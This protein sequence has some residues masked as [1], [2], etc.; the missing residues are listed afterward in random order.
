MI[1][2]QW[3][4]VS[5]KRPLSI[6]GVK[7][8]LLGNRCAE[9]SMFDQTLRDLEAHLG[10]A[11][12]D[13][14]AD[15]MA[16]RISEGR[17]I[18]LA[19]D[20]DCDGITSAAQ[21]A[22]FLTDIGYRN[23][24]VA[25]PRREEG[26]G[27]PERAVHEHPDAGLFVAMDCGTLDVKAVTTARATGAACI[28]IDHHEV[29][30]KGLAP[31]SVLINPKQRSCPSEFKEFC[32]AGLT[33]L[34]LA[35][36]RRAL[37]GDF[38]DLK[39]GGKYLALAAIGTVADMAP[40]VK[41]NRIIV[42][43]GLRSIND[44][45]SPAVMEIAAVAGLSGKQ[46]TSGH[47]GYYIGPRV[48]AAGRMGDPAV[49]FRLLTSEN[50]EEITNLARDLNL[51]NAGRQRQEEIILQEIKER[52]TDDHARRRTFVMGDAGW[53]P[54]VIGIV[55]SRV[56]QEIH[57]GPAIVF[58][59]DPS[60]GVARGSARSVPGFDIHLALTRCEDLLTRWGGHKMAAGM[61]VEL[62]RL[63]AFAARFE[64]VAQ[65]FSPDAFVPKGRVDMELELGLIGPQLLDLLTLLEPYGLGNP[66]PVFAARGARVVVEKTFGKERNHLRLRFGNGLEGIYW[67]GA[68]RFPSGHSGDGGGLDVVFNVEWDS[69]C[70]KTILNVRDV[71]RFF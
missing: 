4:I 39:L 3:Q 58:T 17:K 18:V 50:L 25:I 57:Y 15:I 64:S 69:F 26:Y 9:A 49:A 38:P 31:A 16:Q 65:D 68:D 6:E 60:N 54:G 5:Q 29:P 11:G 41:G 22:H 67:R 12:L 63:E 8:V 24:V 46:I 40:L 21:M 20:Y 2:P 7:E 36:L 52:Y 53:P 43:A 19:G 13:E 66:T 45:A 37:R 51:L 71:G 61:T 23:F 70:R 62:D 32:S 10:I 14:A 47:L 42:K 56:Q 30:E 59:F 28:V 1:Q 34:F 27:M 35:R 55:A 33:L 44:G 48:N